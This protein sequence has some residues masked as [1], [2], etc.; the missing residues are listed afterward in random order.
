MFR[1]INSVFIELVNKSLVQSSK[2]IQ[3]NKQTNASNNMN[4][5]SMN[6]K[7][8][9]LRKFIKRNAI[10]IYLKEKKRIF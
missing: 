4:R 2:H 1:Q 10:L 5:E 7:S 8:A 3:T 9:I 6:E